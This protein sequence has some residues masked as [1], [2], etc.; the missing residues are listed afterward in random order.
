[1]GQ[2]TTAS[3]PPKW[4]TF[5]IQEVERA[6]ALESGLCLAC[7]FMQECCE[8]DARKYQCDRC[9]ECQVYGAEEVLLMGLVS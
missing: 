4:R 7:G 6:S 1:M 9:N 2:T 5:T 8:P 3:R